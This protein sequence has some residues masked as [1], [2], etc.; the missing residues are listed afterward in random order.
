MPVLHHGARATLLFTVIGF[1]VAAAACAPPGSSAPVTSASAA[2][3][4]PPASASPAAG[5]SGAASAGSA[6]AAS[7]AGTASD[8][9]LPEWA[10]ESVPDAV[11]NRRAL[12]FCGVEKPPAPQPMIFVDP[13]ARLCFRDAAE[14]GEE[15]EWVS[16]RGTMEGGTVATIYRVLAD[17]TI[18]LLTDWTQD[19][20]GT[21]G[22]VRTTCREVVEAE[23]DELIAVDGCDDGVPLP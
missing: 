7:S 14:N 3:T 16:I 11:A 10:D 18:E 1:A 9:W 12:R 8:V 20:F 23:G 19:P 22:W 5:P 15:A 17:G 6:G 2:A 13:I 21:G 4:D